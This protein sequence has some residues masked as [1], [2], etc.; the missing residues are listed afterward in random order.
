MAYFDRD[1]ASAARAFHDTLILACNPHPLLSYKNGAFATTIT[2]SRPVLSCLDLLLSSPLTLP[3]ENKVFLDLRKFLT[4]YKACEAKGKIN[5]F[6]LLSQAIPFMERLPNVFNTDRRLRGVKP[7]P[8]MVVASPPRDFKDEDTNN[9]VKMLVC[10]TVDA[11]VLACS[12]ESGFR[13]GIFSSTMKRSTPLIVMLGLLSR[14]EDSSDRHGGKIF[15]N[16]LV[17][18]RKLLELQIQGVTVIE[19]HTLMYFEHRKWFYPML[20]VFE[21]DF[22]ARRVKKP[23][24]RSYKLFPEPEDEDLQH[25][26][27]DP[28]KDNAGIPWPPISV[29]AIVVSSDKPPSVIKI[30]AKTSKRCSSKSFDA[31]FENNMRG[32]F[33]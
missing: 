32:A 33:L 13:H 22:E 5:Q 29:P 17:E 15:T 9:H 8:D 18:A 27:A 21:K 20:R 30:E 14:D 6:D 31:G 26:D 11:I 1:Y 16:A 23:E 12:N 10:I 19:P 24:F 28:Y 3:E 25:L 4:R 7:P 2:S